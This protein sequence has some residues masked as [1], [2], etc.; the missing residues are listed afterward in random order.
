M[1]QLTVFIPKH[2]LFW[3]HIHWISL[4]SLRQLQATRSAAGV[5]W[6]ARAARHGMQMKKKKMRKV[7]ARR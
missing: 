2:G 7:S 1:M 5:N 3:N 4:F 6:E